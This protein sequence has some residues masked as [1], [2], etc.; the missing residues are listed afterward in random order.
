MRSEFARTSIVMSD[1]LSTDAVDQQEKKDDA[2]DDFDPWIYQFGGYPS[3]YE[4]KNE[5]EYEVD[6]NLM[7][8]LP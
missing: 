6:F 8:D 5:N 2:E 7:D 4:D 1:S 3:V